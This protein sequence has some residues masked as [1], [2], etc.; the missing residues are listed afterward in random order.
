[1]TGVRASADSGNGL[2]R[3]A[4]ERSGC[5]AGARA[6]GIR[7]RARLKGNEGMCQARAG[8]RTRGD[9]DVHTYILQIWT[10]RVK[11]G[12]MA[13]SLTFS[14]FKNGVDLDEFVTQRLETS[15]GEARIKVCTVW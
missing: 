4:S 7:M 3:D 8:M 6:A 2:V 11:L 15:I 14:G 9:V 13:R 12:D 1:M 10:S 5:L